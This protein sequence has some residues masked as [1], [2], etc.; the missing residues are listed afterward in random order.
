MKN[1]FAAA[2]AAL[3][4]AQSGLVASQQF[5]TPGWEYLYTAN[6]TLGQSWSIGDTGFGNRVV[7]PITGGTFSGPRLKGTISNLGADWGITDSKGVFFPDT[8]YNLRTNDGVN[9][10]IQTSGPTQSNG[11][12][13]LRGIFQV[14]SGNYEWLNY[15]VASGILKPGGGGVQIEMWAVSLHLHLRVGVQV[16]VANTLQMTAPK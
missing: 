16:C 6:C 1:L 12:I 8:R 5:G 13:F 9:I 4:L 3:G 7:I 2:V 10:F 15:V 14:G 11:Q